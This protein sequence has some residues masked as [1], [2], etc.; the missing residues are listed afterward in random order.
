ME[1]G[2]RHA[3]RMAV[4]KLSRKVGELGDIL[5]EAWTL[6]ETDGSLEV[7]I[8]RTC[9]RLETTVQAMEYVLQGYRVEQFHEFWQDAKAQ[10]EQVM[11]EN[12]MCELAGIF[13]QIL[14]RISSWEKR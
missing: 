7:Q 14:E 11:R 12:T 5:E 4:A 13:D 6:V 8:V 10:K 2:K 9:D 1:Q 3:E